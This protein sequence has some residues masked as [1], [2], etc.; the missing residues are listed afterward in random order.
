MKSQRP[1]ARLF[2][3]LLLNL[4]GFAI[5]IPVLPALAFALGGS[6]VDVGLLYAVQALG[7]FLMAPGWGA[8]SDR[9]GRTKVLTGTFLAAALMEIFTA[10]TGSLAILYV[11]RFLVGLCAGNIATATALIADSTGP[12]N[13]S[14]GM[15]IIGI[16]FGIGF[17]LGPA[18]G[19]AV[20]YVAADG[21]GIL[22]AGLPF[23]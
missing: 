5:S 10:F 15:A 9:F 18:I 14:K 12:E 6:A 21:P 3:I 17:T 20:S 16:S 19:A 13:R 1:L 11:A 4:T 2:P 7:Q 23:A 8:L 22:G